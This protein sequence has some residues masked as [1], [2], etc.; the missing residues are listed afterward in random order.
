MTLHVTFL[1]DYGYADEFAGVCR[2]VIAR[3]APDAALIDLTHGIPRHDVRAGARV[4]AAAVAYAPEGVHL[5]VVDPGVGTPRRA[6]AARSGDGRL[7]VG[8]D[9]G[10]LW[11]A[12]QRCGGVAEFFD[13]SLSR[14][15]LEP[16]HATF[17]GRDVFAPIAAHLAAGVPLTEVGERHE[18]DELVRLEASVARLEGDRVVAA[19]AGV[20]GFGNVALD[21][22]ERE[23]GAAGLKL[24]RGLRVVAGEAGVDAV[25]A[26]TFADAEPGELIFYLDSS[27]SLALAINRGSAAER[28]G[29]AAGDEVVLSPQ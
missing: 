4:L 18:P 25:Y 28:L 14:H 5:A 19:V 27:A 16:V 3:I 1:S 10:L 6:V 8:P 2:A 29:L 21:L 17:H 20:D 15:R 23:A 12:L 22:S 24:G 26:H 7:F 13:V 11:P 9:N